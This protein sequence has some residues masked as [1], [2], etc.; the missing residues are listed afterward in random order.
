MAL[1]PIYNHASSSQLHELE[2]RRLILSLAADQGVLYSRFRL[3][4][5]AEHAVLS[6]SDA[7]QALELFGCWRPHLVLLDY[8]LSKINGDVVAEAIEAHSPRTPIVMV[9]KDIEMVGR[10][11]LNVD[12]FLFQNDGPQKLLRTLNDLLES[13]KNP[14]SPLSGNTSESIL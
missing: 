12:R 10:C 11:T 3:L 6:A 13:Q 4:S 9:I 7:A 8:V 5:S 14:R 2:G 1:K